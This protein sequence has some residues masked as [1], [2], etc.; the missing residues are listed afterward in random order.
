MKEFRNEGKDEPEL[1]PQAIKTPMEFVM[2]MILADCK[3]LGEQIWKKK[4]N[5]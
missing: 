4:I 3:S 5:K 2:K 1:A